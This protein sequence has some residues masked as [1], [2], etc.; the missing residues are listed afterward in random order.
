MARDGGGWAVNYLFNVWQFCIITCI[1]YSN[2]SEKGC[3]AEY[4]LLNIT[5]ANDITF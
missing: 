5:F 4:F 2:V 1:N 3:S